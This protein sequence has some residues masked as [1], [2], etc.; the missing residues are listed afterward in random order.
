MEGEEAGQFLGQKE[1]KGWLLGKIAWKREDGLTPAGQNHT[2][3]VKVSLGRGLFE[4]VR[5]KRWL[6]LSIE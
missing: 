4:A 6:R 2:H 3:R 5:M 1:G